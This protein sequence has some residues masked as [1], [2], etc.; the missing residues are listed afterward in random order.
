MGFRTCLKPETLNFG[1]SG[2]RF[3]MR[4]TF[5]KLQGKHFGFGIQAFGILSVDL[6]FWAFGV[7][8][9]S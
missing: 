5:V 3:R 4:A 6:G 7:L 1:V 2:V 9:K 8:L